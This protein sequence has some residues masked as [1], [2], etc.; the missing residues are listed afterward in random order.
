MVHGEQEKESITG[1]IHASLNKNQGLLKTIL[2]FSR[3]NSL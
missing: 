2:Q 1:F 3:T